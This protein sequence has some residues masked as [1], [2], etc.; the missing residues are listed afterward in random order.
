MANDFQ[1]AKDT[2]NALLSNAPY[3]YYPNSSV[4]HPD[5]TRMLSSYRLYNNEIDQEDFA[6]DCNP[7]GIEVGQVADIIRPYNKTYNKIQVLLSDEL[8]RPFNYKVALVNS[9]GINSK[10]AHR[11]SLLRSFIYSQ[12]QETIKEISP[13]YDPQLLEEGTKHIMNPE[14]IERYMSTTYKDA[15]E[16]LASKILN[17]LTHKL[18]LKQ[19]KNDGFKHALLSAIEA[20]YVTVRNGEP[21]IQTL[22]PLN[23]F[24]HKSPETYHIEDSLYAGYRSYLTSGEVIDQY[25]AYLTEDDLQDIEN[26]YP[27]SSLRTV[28]P[29]PEMKYGHLP[30]PNYPMSG[31]SSAITPLHTVE[32]VEWVSQKRVGFVTY[33][34]P[35]GPKSDWV[36]EDFKV[37]ANHTKTVIE[38]DYGRKCTYYT[39]SDLTTT[40]TLEWMYVPEVWQGVRINRSVY[41]QIGPVPHQFR[42]MDNPFE[43]KLSYHGVV[44]NATNATPTSLMD[45]MKPFQYLY[46]IVMH[47]LKKLIAQDAGKVYN[48]D[49]SM[50]DPKMG[51]EKTVYYLKELNI[52]FFNPLNNE[53][54]V[55][56]LA[57]RSTVQSSTDMSNT[58]HILNYINLLAAIDQQ[59]SDV[60]GVTRQR[61]GQINPQE[62][63]GNAEASRQSSALITEMYFYQHNQLWK[64][65]LSTL[66]SMTQQAWKE[67]SVVKQF[68]LDDLSLATLE[69]SP[70]DLDNSQYGVFVTDSAREQKMFESLQMMSESLVQANKAKFSDLIELYAATSSQ[71]LASKIRQSEDLAIQQAAQQQQ[72]EIQAQMQMAQEKQAWESSEREKDRI[73]KLHIAEIDSMKF[74]RD[75]DS[76][77][78]G[79]PDQLEIEKF[80]HQV[81][82]DEQKLD[83]E[84]EKVKVAKNRATRTKQ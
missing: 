72:Q 24:Y 27:G 15:R 62:A 28:L 39:W 13:M 22:N 40:Y 19:L 33:E 32:H 26:K 3:S 70:D 48:F 76:D 30:Y 20:V 79:V 9:E 1:W 4:Q 14:Q 2:I 68:V 35:E 63:V 58:A 36:N 56:G 21:V 66:L 49:I 57:Q 50:V 78:N 65:V 16:I 67:K 60:A 44:Y 17:Y 71:E 82:M 81:E 51:L 53:E 41:C 23:L 42:S 52:N 80:R 77:N 84:R 34:T 29:G 54:V 61:E 45:R 73:N 31:G 37:P 7:L 59:I 55:P 11:D 18:S 69:L 83:I 12:I 74:L 38:K 43:V 25:G 10:L 8:M 6:R 64:E 46:L 75:Q 5:Y 47:K